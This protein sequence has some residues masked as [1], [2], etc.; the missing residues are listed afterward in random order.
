MENLVTK[1]RRQVKSNKYMLICFFDEKEIVY[2]ESVTYGKLMLI[3]SKHWDIYRKM[4]HWGRDLTN[5]GAKQFFYH[6]NARAHSILLIQQHT[7][8]F[9]PLY[10]P[11][12]APCDFFLF[13]KLKLKLKGHR[14]QMVEDI[15][16][17]S[18]AVLNMLGENDY[19]GC[20]QTWQH[21]WNHCQASKQDYFE[22]D[23]NHWCFRYTLFVLPYQ[24][25]VA[26]L[27]NLL[28]LLFEGFLLV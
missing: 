1:G 13:P 20:F 5:G 27:D 4:W 28:I 23:G 11:D 25:K 6:S 18:Q 15:Q 24:V 22:V 21:C 2:Q 7:V 9:H 12:L 10:S 26:T 14:F 3:L 17:E 19:Q 16:A 8:V